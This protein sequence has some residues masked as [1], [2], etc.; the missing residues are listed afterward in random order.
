MKPKVN[1]GNN[2]RGLLAYA[3][4]VGSKAGLNKQAEIVGGNM[5]GSNIEE[6]TQEFTTIQRLRPDIARPVWHCSLSL[7]FGERLPSRKWSEVI[8][9]FMVLMKFPNNIGHV[10]IRHQDTDFDHIHLAVCRVGLDGRVWLGRHEAFSA[11]TAVQTLEKKFG[12][13]LTPGLNGKRPDVAPPTDGELNEQKRTGDVPLRLQLQAILDQAV[14][15]S[16]SA[17]T[18][19]QR[20]KA[21]NV[22][23]RVN[24]DKK[25]EINGISF[26]LEG[27]KFKGSDLGKNYAWP[28]LQKR[29]LSYER[30]RDYAAL[31]D[32]GRQTDQPVNRG[33]LS[34]AVVVEGLKST[35][36]SIDPS[37]PSSQ[38]SIKNTGEGHAETYDVEAADLSVVSPNAAAIKEI[39]LENSQR[40][41]SDEEAAAIGSFTANN[42]QDAKTAGAH[43][44]IAES[45][46]SACGNM[47]MDSELVAM[48]V[49]EEGGGNNSELDSRDIAVGD[50][51]LEPA[52]DK[53]I[54]PKEEFSI[55]SHE[56]VEN[57]I[58][59][60]E[61]TIKS[62]IEDVVLMEDKSSFIDKNTSVNDVSLEENDEK[63]STDINTIS[64]VNALVELENKN[65]NMGIVSSVAPPPFGTQ[66]EAIP[67]QAV[68]I[69]DKR[70]LSEKL[71]NLE[72]N[73][74]ADS[75]KNSNKGPEFSP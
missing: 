67:S 60:N 24:F 14:A 34:A 33:E 57:D 7:P 61:K 29:G 41:I 62:S 32:F 55:L 10:G 4:G 53:V 43:E 64:E 8:S 2:M 63:F 75:A 49:A 69:L 73:F 39:S 44:H 25:G 68:V 21:E 17:S 42:S 31:A 3:L 45:T 20:L 48:S 16:P 27:A 40:R 19:A 47:K 5:S 22:G 72:S 66:T 58:Q 15:D 74:D 51:L 18:F 1:R 46:E 13:T 12:L 38:I 35:T 50:L 71:A 65:D 6:L 54:A 9:E 37:K 26:E 36:G 30:E 70:K 59:T 23:V 28:G 52:D 56:A 11:I